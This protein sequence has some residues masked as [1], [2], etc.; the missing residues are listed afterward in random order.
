MCNIIFTC[1]SSRGSR[2]ALNWVFNIMTARRFDANSFYRTGRPL[3][4]VTALEAYH[5]L[6]ESFH[7]RSLSGEIS[8]RGFRSVVRVFFVLG[9]EFR[10]NS[11][12][13]VKTT[14]YLSALCLSF[15][16]SRAFLGPLSDLKSGRANV[17]YVLIKLHFSLMVSFRDATADCWLITSTTIK[18][19]HFLN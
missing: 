8:A 3:V 12:S 18:Y 2:N 6:C 10:L 16:F 1:M 14:L 11:S 9:W 15:L 5:Q 13:P 7:W 19:E 4:S 17:M